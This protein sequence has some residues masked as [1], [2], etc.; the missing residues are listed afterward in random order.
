MSKWGLSDLRFLYSFSYSIF[1]GQYWLLPGDSGYSHTKPLRRSWGPFKLR[2]ALVLMAAAS[3][4]SL[5]SFSD[6]WIK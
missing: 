1:H 5:P 4:P 3:A 2:L 6:L